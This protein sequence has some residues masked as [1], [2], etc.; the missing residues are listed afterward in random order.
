MQPF[1][2]IL[3]SEKIWILYF[4]KTLNNRSFS[5]YIIGTDRGQLAYFRACS[6]KKNNY[7]IDRFGRCFLCP[8]YGICKKEILYFTDGYFVDWEAIDS[9][10]PLYLKFIEN[11]DTVGNTYDVKYSNMIGRFPQANRCLNLKACK[12]YN[13]TTKCVNGHKGFLC[14]DCVEG[15]YNNRNVCNV[16]PGRKKTITNITVAIVLLLLLILMVISLVLVKTKKGELNKLL[17]N[18]KICMNYLYFSS[19]MYE[20]MNFMHW[21]KIMLSFIYFLKWIELNPLDLLSV[22]CW[23]TKFSLYEIYITFVSINGCIFLVTTFA[24]LALKS[25]HQCGKVGNENMKKYRKSVIA[26]AAIMLFF[27]YTPT[28]IS[29]VQLLPVACKAFYLSFPEKMEV[30]YFMQDPVAKCFTGYHIKMLNYVYVSLI[31]VFGIPVAVPIVIWYLRRKSYKEA[32]VCL[33]KMTKSVQ[34]PLQED[35]GHIPDVEDKTEDS[36]S[37]AEDIYD[38]LEFFYGNYK[39]KYFFWESLEMTKKLFL[40]SIAVFIGDTS[41]TSLALLIMFSGVFAVLHA[42]FQPIAST[43]EHC[44]Q[45]LCLS[46]LHVQLLLGLSMKIESKY[47]NSDTKQDIDALGWSLLICNV[48]I[49]VLIF[50]KCHFN[51]LVHLHFFLISFQ[52]KSSPLFLFLY[53]A[54]MIN[55][56]YSFDVGLSLEEFCVKRNYV[57]SFLSL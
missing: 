48:T 51:I 36:I 55:P 17:S 15:Y 12:I 6:C 27:L 5:F 34:G 49:T 45:L 4:L 13:F 39:Q 22:T 43:L 40:A 47:V 54:F 56:Y 16:C 19:K 1:I 14:A 26:I 33:V 8:V 29:I 3:L 30:H 38:G 10:V 9:S 11:I 31:Y 32:E 53:F 20:V 21:S 2:F 37:I 42:H 44:T 7:R 24:I 57:I 18:A 52:I 35:A 25:S 23:I 28:S 41:Y 50:G 46:A